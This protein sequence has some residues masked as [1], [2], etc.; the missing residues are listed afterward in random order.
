MDYSH[1]NAVYLYRDE[2]DAGTK[3][4]LRRRVMFSDTW[5][6][7]YM[8]FV[9]RNLLTLCSGLAYRKRANRLDN[10][11]RM[12]ALIFD[13]D[14]VGKRE[15]KNLIYRFGKEAEGQVRTLPTPTYLVLS[16]NGVHLYYVFQEPVDLYPNIKLQ[17]KAMKHA[18]TFRIWE[19]QATST[20]KEIQYQSINQ[21]FRMVGSINERHGTEVRAF[22]VG[23]RVTLDYLN[24]YTRADSRVD[25]N[26]PFRPSV[27]T[28]AEA[29]G[30]YPEWYERV[31]I[32]K[33]R[34]LKKW[35]IAGKQGD[36]L[37]RWWLEKADTIKG[38]H[39]YFFMMCLAIYACKCDIPKKRL[40][41]DMQAA[42]DILRSIEHESGDIL[43]QNDVD[44]A[45]EAYGKEYYNFTIS[46][47]ERLSG[48][49]I[50]RN[51]RNG[52]K[53]ADHIKLMN[54]IRDEINKNVNWR[55]GAGRP[56]GS[57]TKKD[58][59]KN[60]RLIKPDA[61]KIDCHR[62]TGLSRTTIDKWWS[63]ADGKE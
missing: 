36:S 2:E 49:R 26:K 24:P 43:M 29:K 5:G 15:I 17:M 21:G 28:R 14:G 59:I 52:R 30:K 51:K 44:S 6:N 25:V 35:D 13:F 50:E 34:K 8:E 56:S 12:N 62:D 57:G 32:G 42:F 22:R 10:A 4:R 3:R 58:I 23:E 55:E 1:P 19:Y 39:R 31:V 53:Q 41:E 45:M 20:Q 63:A 16:G 37:Y 60:Y 9:E 46:D 18:L 7:D 47:I 61:K 48:L 33:S 38:G 11:Q 54:F 27:M 40:R